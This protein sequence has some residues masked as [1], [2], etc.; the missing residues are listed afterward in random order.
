M[1]LLR[2]VW[3]LIACA[4]YPFRLLLFW[5][6]SIFI[7]LTKPGA[8]II[9]PLAV[10][11]LATWWRF[12][13]GEPVEMFVDAFG[14]LYR[15]IINALFGPAWGQLAYEYRGSISG[16]IVYFVLSLAVSLISAIL[17]PFVH[18]LPPPRRPF[19]PL[20]PLRAPKHVVGVEPVSV[21]VQSPGERTYSGDLARMLAR[22]PAEIREVIARPY[23]PAR[24]AVEASPVEPPA[25]PPHPDP[26]EPD[27]ERRAAP[28]PA[29][30]PGAKRKPTLSE[31]D[32]GPQG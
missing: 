22:L 30:V 26:I 18:A 24:M 27:R 17:H 19:L 9:L 2:F 3:F 7:F 20:A 14:G 25:T 21:V 31:V 12:S 10:V 8:R 6:H 5:L 11:L 32:R 1:T 28:G 16:V 13:Y 4:F 23:E 29:K 15:D